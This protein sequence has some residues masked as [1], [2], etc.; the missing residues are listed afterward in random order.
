MYFEVRERVFVDGRLLEYGFIDT[1]LRAA[2]LLQPMFHRVDFGSIALDNAL[3]GV[4][5]G[6]AAPAVYR[7]FFRF[8]LCVLTKKDTLYP[9]EYFEIDAK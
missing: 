8:S 6:V 5:V 4:L 9:A 3:Y 7:D 1:T 2:Y